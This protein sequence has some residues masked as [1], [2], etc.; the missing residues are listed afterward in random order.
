MT[1]FTIRRVWDEAM[2]FTEGSIYSLARGTPAPKDL[3]RAIFYPI[4]KTP[5]RPQHLSQ[6]H[7]RSAWQSLASNLVAISIEACHLSTTFCKIANEARHRALRLA[8]LMELVKAGRL[9]L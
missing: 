5:P 3:G 6:G 9:L 1:S 8:S 4:S 7:E 2:A